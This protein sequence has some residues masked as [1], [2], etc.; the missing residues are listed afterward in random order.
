MPPESPQILE[1]LVANPPDN[2]NTTNKDLAP[3]NRPIIR[4]MFVIK[5]L[6]V[7][8]VTRRTALI[9][10]QDTDVAARF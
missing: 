7:A 4:H 9:A 6:V 1:E 2:L 3:L 8:L 5:G 10:Q